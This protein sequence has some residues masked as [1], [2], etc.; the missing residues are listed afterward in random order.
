MTVTDWWLT[1]ECFRL[2]YVPTTPVFTYSSGLYLSV[3]NDRE[4][5]LVIAKSE[6]LVM[7]F[8][9]FLPLASTVTPKIPFDMHSLKHPKVV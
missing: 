1:T 5:I 7:C 6:N 4:R 3:G 2:L 9:P 8:A